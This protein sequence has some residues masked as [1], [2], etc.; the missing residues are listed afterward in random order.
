[1]P[2]VMTVDRLRKWFPLSKGIVR[3]LFRSS[4]QIYVRAV[5]GVSFEIGER[6]VLG[7][8]GESGSGKTVTGELLTK[9]Q[10]P[11]HGKLMFHEQ[12]VTALQK[13]RR[14]WF[15]RNVQMIFQDPYETLNPRFTVYNSVAEPLRIHHIGA[16][17]ERRER[18]L[19]SLEHVG[20]QPAEKYLDKY[21]HEMSGGQRQRVAIARA[22]ISE[23]SF[24]VAD[25]PTSMLDVSIRA[26]ILRLLDSFKSTLNLSM[27]FI[28]HDFSTIRYLCDRTAI[29]YLGK[30]LEIG[31]TK[32]LIRNPH[33]P[34]TKALLSAIPVVNF[35]HKRKR[36]DI[37]GDVASAVRLPVG[38]RFSSRC[39]SKMKICE[40]TEPEMVEMEPSHS[41][42]CHR[43]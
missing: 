31:A 17:T 21:P 22:I 30:I 15:R 26:G 40:E 10:E 2:K 27:L 23:P 33:H 42:A 8:A 36:V 29:M 38:C 32:Q 9:L 25:E 35:R 4:E 14:M 7:L 24:I 18:V 12:D 34:Y 39:V 3:S 6:E 11:T 28:S 37:K 19:S 41:V 13:E 1:M 5:D 16:R 20:L 43:R